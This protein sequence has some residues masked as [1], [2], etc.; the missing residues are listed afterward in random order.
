[1]GEG[2]EEPGTGG[3]KPESRHQEQSTRGRHRR[4]KCGEGR[5]H[6]AGSHGKQELGGGGK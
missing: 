1:M 3:G 6:V 5:G 4:A 2:G